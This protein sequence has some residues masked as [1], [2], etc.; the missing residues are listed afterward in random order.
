MRIQLLG[1]AVLGTMSFGTAAFGIAGFGI[2][3]C[4]VIIQLE[5]NANITV[6]VT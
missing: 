1:T 2:V 3:T 5:Q 4:L 6:N